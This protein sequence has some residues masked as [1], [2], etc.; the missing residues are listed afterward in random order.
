MKVTEQYSKVFTPR[1]F[2]RAQHAAITR[3]RRNR[4]LFVQS[5]ACKTEH[6]NETIAAL[7]WGFKYESAAIDQYS[8]RASIACL[9]C[10]PALPPCMTC[11]HFLP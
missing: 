2:Y 1:H 4:L 7:K 9:L 10:L 3:E 11:L 6:L 8:R 5:L